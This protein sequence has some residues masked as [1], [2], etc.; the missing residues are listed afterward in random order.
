MIALLPHDQGTILPVRAHAGARK[1]AIAGV[2]ADSLRVAVS[3]PPE[4][5]KA[6][7]AIQALLAETLGCKTSQIA[8]LSGETSRQ[9][10]FLVVGIDPEEIR[11][12]LSPWLAP[13]QRTR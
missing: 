10:R 7:A 4:K 13:E 11:K 2:H 1:S 6:N 3:A 8:L 5:G 12:R 9:K